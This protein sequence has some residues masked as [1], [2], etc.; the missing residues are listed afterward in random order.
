MWCVY[1]IECTDGTLYTGITNNIKRRLFEHNTD[2]G[3]K[4]TRGRSPVRLSECR[5]FPTKSIAL[6][7]ESKIKKLPKHKKEWT[8]ARWGV[9]HS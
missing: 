9:F 3:A 4:Y 5:A 1:I 8:L 6:S 7:I 2:N